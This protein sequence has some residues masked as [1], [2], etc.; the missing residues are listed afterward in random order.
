MPGA[1]PTPACK[2]DQRIIDD[3]DA[4]LVAD[5]AHDAADDGFV[6]CAIDAGDAEAD[7]RRND[8]CARE[9]LFHHGVQHLFERELA[10]ALKIRAFLAALGDDAR[11]VVGEQAH[12]LRAA[13][14]DAE[15]RHYRYI[16]CMLVLSGADLVLPDGVQRGGTLVIEGDRIVDILRDPAHRVRRDVRRTVRRMRMSILRV[17][18]SLPG[19][20]DVH[21]HGLEG[22]DTLDGTDAIQAIAAAASEVWRDSVLSDDC[23]VQRREALRDVLESV[24]DASRRIRRTSAARVLPAHLESNFINPEYRGAQPRGM[25]AQPASGATGPSRGRDE[26]RGGD[27][28][29][30]RH[31]G[32]NRSMRVTAS[33]SSRWRPSSTARSI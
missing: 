17:I 4:R 2:R 13:D 15:N 9:R 24:G 11:V 10:G 7:R 32:G 3:E 23:R 14:V 20:I 33:A 27:F 5:A 26:V 25:P 31:P 8:A 16:T 1:S 18:S 22:I 6:R 28:D 12:R 19:F 29:G 30:A 21:V